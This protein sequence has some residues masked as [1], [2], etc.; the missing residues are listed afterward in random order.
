MYNL[1]FLTFIIITLL[2]VILYLSFKNPNV[3][4]HIMS[5]LFTI[6]L[7]FLG[8]FIFI[9]FNII[10]LRF[11]LDTKKIVYVEDIPFINY[12]GW[13]YSQFFAQ[14]SRWFR[15]NPCYVHDPNFCKA[16]DYS[17]INLNY[18]QVELAAWYEEDLYARYLE[19]LESYYDE[20]F[21]EI[22]NLFI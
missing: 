11:I 20:T 2:S 21:L 3:K 16:V 10:C 5:G 9:S 14:P 8:V 22:F 6:F 19:Y 13:Y 4:P 18:A 12:Q 17:T 15:L 1:Y 7:C